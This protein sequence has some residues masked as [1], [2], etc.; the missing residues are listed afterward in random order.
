[1]ATA[2]FDDKLY[3]IGG[4]Q[5][6]LRCTNRVEYFN[7]GENEWHEARGMTADR[8]CH[9]AVVLSGLPYVDDYIGRRKRQE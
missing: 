3:A 9:C 2:V 4:C 5:R 6:F 8:V 1:M 7:E